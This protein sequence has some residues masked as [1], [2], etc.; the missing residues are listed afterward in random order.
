MESFEEA[1]GKVEESRTL[2]AVIDSNEE[3][4]IDRFI[5]EIKMGGSD[6]RRK[7]GV[8]VK[9]PVVKLSKSRSMGVLHS[10]Q[11]LRYN[12]NRG[13]GLEMESTVLDSREVEASMSKLLI[14]LDEKSEREMQEKPLV[15]II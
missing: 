8:A 7:A 12:N 14:G 1:R 10:P 3:I 5:R 9:I 4:K 13:F 11:L 6:S 2:E 15:S